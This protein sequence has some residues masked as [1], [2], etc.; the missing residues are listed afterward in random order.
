MRTFRGINGGLFDGEL[1]L[2]LTAAEI[3]LM[4]RA[5]KLEWAE[6]EP[7]IFG[8][9]F[10]RS[11]DPGKR[12]QL[13]AHYSSRDDIMRIVE[14]VVMRPLR[15]CWDEVRTIAEEYLAAE[16]PSNPRIA[17]TKRKELVDGL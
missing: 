15:R 1:A 9:L 14:P 6:V 13:G 3:E 16:P 4:H 5:A 8:T 10:E 2:P 11:L 7:V 17:A 12:S